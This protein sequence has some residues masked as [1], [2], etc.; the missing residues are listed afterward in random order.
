MHADE[1]HD[2][3]EAPGGRHRRAL[4]RRLR[5]RRHLHRRRGQRHDD[6]HAH[7]RRR[8]SRWRSRPRTRR[9]P[10]T[11]PRR[12]TASPRRTRPS[13]S[14]ATRSPRRPSSRAWASCTSRSTSSACSASTACEV[15]VGKPQVAYRETIT[16]RGRVRL[17]AQE[18]DRRLGPVRAGVRLHRAAAGRRGRELRVRRRHRRRRDPRE[19]IPACDKGF[20][21]AWSE[22]PAHR[23]PGGGRALRDQRRRF[24]RGRLVRNG[25]QDRGAHGASARP[26][27][28]PSRSSSSRS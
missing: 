17:H 20:K 6:L 19:F 21:E 16:Q 28:R 7:P 4:R 3:D 5:V 11:S 15:I 24:A 13:A 27:P 18:A 23:V 26:T 12:S 2:I 1:M 22:G 25:L 9:A 8:S 14:T 10:P